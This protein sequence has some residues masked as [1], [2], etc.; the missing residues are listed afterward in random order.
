[1][2]TKI[3]HVTI[4]GSRLDTLQ[5][6]FAEAGLATDYGGPH[7]NNVTHMA[8]LGFND[9]SYIELISTLE[10]GQHSPWWDA[11]IR[12]D[13]G[14]CAWALEVDD[15]AAEAHRV[16]KLGVPVNGPTHYARER[17]DGVRIEWDLAILGDQGMGALLPFIIKDRTPRELRVSLSASVAG[18]GLTGVALVVVAVP[19]IESASQLF[20]RAYELPAPATCE[21]HELG[22]R[23]A[24]FP[25]Q[26]F[27]F[28]A[29]SSADSWLHERLQ[30]FGVSPCAYLIGSTDTVTTAKRL[31]LTRARGWSGQPLAWLT[32]QT[33]SHLRVGVI[34][35]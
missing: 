15:V 21:W 29:P 14:P 27:A 6:A 17:P 4:A 18:T 20:Q 10:P 8:L 19:V 33:A 34:D 9:G 35:V 28:A 7:S 11:P 22:A 5:R 13:G 23:F 32:L 16:A 30:R 2:K 3:D 12:N 25:G 26:P 24:Y 31:P 1:M